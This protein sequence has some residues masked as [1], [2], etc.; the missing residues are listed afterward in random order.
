[1][2][3]LYVTLCSTS[4]SPSGNVNMSTLAFSL[5][6]AGMSGIPLYDVDNLAYVR[7]VAGHGHGAGLVHIMRRHW[8]LFHLSGRI[9]VLSS[10]T[11]LAV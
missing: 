7:R 8:F 9:D 10:M 4:M 1:M 3:C 6:G 2:I 11:V 5:H